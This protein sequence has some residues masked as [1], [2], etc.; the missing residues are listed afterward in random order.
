MTRWPSCPSTQARWS[1]CHVASAARTF[2]ASSCAKASSFSNCIHRFTT[3]PV[4][5][6][7]QAKASSSVSTASFGSLTSR[8][9]M[10]ATHSA[11]DVRCLMSFGRQFGSG[12]T[13]RGATG[14]PMPRRGSRFPK[15][16]SPKPAGSRSSAGAG[17]GPAFSS[18]SICRRTSR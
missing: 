8:R 7:A 16:S 17:F 10:R 3:F 12:G 6:S 4:S 11:R 18:A 1:F 9:C 13:T 2:P 5:R 15:S 14:R